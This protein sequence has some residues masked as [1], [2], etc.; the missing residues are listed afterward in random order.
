MRTVRPRQ[1]LRALHRTEGLPTPRPI[2]TPHGASLFAATGDEVAIRR[3]CPPKIQRF[4]GVVAP[5]PSSPP[6]RKG[7]NANA[8]RRDDAYAAASSAHKPYSAKWWREACKLSGRKLTT[9]S[10]H[11]GV[12]AATDESQRRS[13]RKVRAAV[14]MAAALAVS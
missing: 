14:V 12:A 3:F 2:M 10:V 4:F 7:L 8:E 9:L 5:Q 13:A 6:A 11:E 1:L